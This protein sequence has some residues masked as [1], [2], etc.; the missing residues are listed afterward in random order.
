MSS[1]VAVAAVAV[2]IVPGAVGNN[3]VRPADTPPTGID[4]LPSRDPDWRPDLDLNRS[5][6]TFRAR[7]AGES[8]LGGAVVDSGQTELRFTVRPRAAAIGMRYACLSAP[9]PDTLVEIVIAGQVKTPADDCANGPVTE[10]LDASGPA[11]P[12][13]LPGFTPG[14]AIPVVIRLVDKGTRRPVTDPTAVLGIGI[15]DPGPV[16]RVGPVGIPET[17]EHQGYLYRLTRLERGTTSDLPLEISTPAGRPFL[18]AIGGYG[19]WHGLSLD[20][21]GMAGPLTPIDQLDGTTGPV[22]I[23]ARP[24]HTGPH[25]FAFVQATR[26][27]GA[28]EMFIALYTPA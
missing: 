2:G 21:D 23:Q 22:M 27:S 11:V 17:Y 6:I 18:L 24:P 16:H 8:L 19:D 26:R 7:I 20:P 10:P 9:R 25:G 28:G 12:L 13:T 14:R 4:G 15:Y 1:T 5:G 3:S